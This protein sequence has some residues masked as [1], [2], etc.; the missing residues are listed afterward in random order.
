MS[1]SHFNQFINSDIPARAWPPAPHARFADIPVG[2]VVLGQIGTYTEVAPSITSVAADNQLRADLA[3]PPQP[4]F[5][6]EQVPTTDPVPESTATT[7]TV[8][9][10][11]A[12]G[13]PFAPSANE[14]PELQAGVPFHPT[15]KRVVQSLAKQ[16]P[17]GRSRVMQ[18]H[19]V[20]ESLELETWTQLWAL[21]N[22]WASTKS[23]PLLLIDAT[24]SGRGLAG[25]LGWQAPQGWSDM[26]NDQAKLS[27]IMQPTA[28][29]TCRFITRGETP[30]TVDDES[31]L[32]LASALKALQRDYRAIW[33]VTSGDWNAQSLSHANRAHTRQLLIPLGTNLADWQRF[34]QSLLERNLLIQ[35][36][37][38]LDSGTTHTTRQTA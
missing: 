27:Q 8:I 15:I 5:V 38:G 18:W 14:L 24:T 29:E 1:R 10:T 7:N 19:A 26:L 2:L 36:W 21:A 20:D 23:D 28:H 9:N 12:D 13:E 30:W 6:P 16:L 22:C 11:S 17:F 25:W 4:L 33:V 31:S 37:L 32:R 3:A 35:G 34:A